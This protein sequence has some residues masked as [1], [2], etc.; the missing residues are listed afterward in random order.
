MD[1]LKWQL[2]DGV[3]DGMT[4]KLDIGDRNKTS[5]ATN[6]A[7]SILMSALT[8]NATQSESGLSGLMGALKKDHDG[9]ILD[10]IM[11]LMTG[12]SQ[13]QNQRMMDGTGILSH[14]LGGKQNGAIDMLMKMSGLDQNQSST[15][16]AKL[17]PMVLGVLGRVKKQNHLDEGGLKDYLKQSQQKFIKEDENRSIFTKL[18]DQDGD[19]NIADDVASIGMK[20]LGNFFKR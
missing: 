3:I 4:Q 19:G 12:R 8:K 9:S 6:A 2:S 15:M 18:L 7:L 14:L 5:N 11:G 17:A 16:L 10:D 1:L 20:V 13:P